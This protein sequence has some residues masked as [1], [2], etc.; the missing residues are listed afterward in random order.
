MQYQTT[1]IILH[2]HKS[3]RIQPAWACSLAA[4]D[5]CLL[6]RWFYRGPAR[7]RYTVLIKCPVRD[8][9]R[10]GIYFQIGPLAGNHPV[11]SGHFAGYK[12]QIA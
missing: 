7:I 2:T 8:T 4:A 10:P 6:P 11:K 12:I 9:S 5:S 3:K 1:T